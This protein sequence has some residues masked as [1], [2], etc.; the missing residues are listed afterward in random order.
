MLSSNN[1]ITVI[2]KLIL[3]VEKP[4]NLPASYRLVFYSAVGLLFATAYLGSLGQPADNF[5]IASVEIIVDAA[6]VWVFLQLAGR[7]ARW[8]QTITALFGTTCLI[9]ILS[10]IPVELVWANVEN[11]PANHFWVGVAVMPFGIWNLAIS[12]L[13]M[14]ESL[15]ISV[16]RAFFISF[17]IALL[18][19]IIVIFILGIESFEI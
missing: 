3:F 15:E 10:H 13:I 11:D 2:A 9:R 8:K 19:S 5:K 16:L 7:A 18:T 6:I 1:P 12:V 14:K 4:Q 17:G